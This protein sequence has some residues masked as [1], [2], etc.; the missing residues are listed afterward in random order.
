[1][2]INLG[3]DTPILTDSQYFQAMFQW[4]FNE[5]YAVLDAQK[6]GIILYFISL[7]SILYFFRYAFFKTFVLIQIIGIIF[8]FIGFYV[9]SSNFVVS[10]QWLKTTIWIKLFGIIALM[11][12]LQK[13]CSRTQKKDSFC[14]MGFLVLASC[15]L[16]FQFNLI[17]EEIW[18]KI[19]ILNK[20]IDDFAPW[21]KDPS[22]RKDFLIETF[23]NLSSIAWELQPFMPETSQKILSSTK[24]K[25]K[26]IAP[27]FPRLK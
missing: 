14:A 19:K 13:I 8:Y 21:K 3:K 12:I 22:E 4:K 11:G 7:A 17:L 24:G 16:V 5:H 18:K 1:M 25:I 2:K 9:F 20:K 26:K 15:V 27:L 6:A 10:L 23:S